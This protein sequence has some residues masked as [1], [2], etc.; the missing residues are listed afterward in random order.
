MFL[1]LIS[2]DQ[3]LNDCGA[4]FHTLGSD[5]DLKISQHRC[6]DNVKA[7]E[8]QREIYVEPQAAYSLLVSGSQP[9][10]LPGVR[11]LLITGSY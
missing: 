10:S 3:L 8:D 6:R 1:D 9:A 7:G 4:L 2:P 5:D 11:M